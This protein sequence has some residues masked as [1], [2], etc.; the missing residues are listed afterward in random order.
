[1][2]FKVAIREHW[3]EEDRAD[4]RL[5]KMEKLSRVNVII[6]IICWC[7]E[8]E[9]HIFQIFVKVRRRLG[10]EFQV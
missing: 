7:K 4:E 10:I 9:N 6:C 8:Q 3:H 2:L 1:M 5:F